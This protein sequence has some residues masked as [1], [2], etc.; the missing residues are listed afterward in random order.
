MTVENA[1][2]LLTLV[3]IKPLLI[4]MVIIAGLLLLHRRSAA[5]QH[6]WLSIGIFSLLLLPLLFRLLPEI[7]WQILPYTDGSSV[8]MNQVYGAVSWISQADR[9]W[10]IAAAYLFIAFWLLFYLLLGIVGLVIQT[11]QA[12]TC[13]DAELQSI[14]Q[15]LIVEMDISRTV[16]VV[17]SDAVLSPHMWGIF[18]PVIMLPRQAERWTGER[19]LSVL[20]HEL[21]H[22]ARYDWATSLAVKLCC[23]FFWFLPPVWWLAGRLFHYA[24]IACDDYI[25]CLQKDYQLR[26]KEAVYA[27]NLLA[28][29]QTAGKNTTPHADPALLMAGHSPIF[30]RIEAILD[31]DRQRDNAR[32]EAR[33]YWVLMVLLLLLPLASIQLIPIQQRLA[34]QVL[35]ITISDGDRIESNAAYKSTVPV[36]QFD[37]ETLSKLKQQLRGESSPVLPVEKMTIIA[38]RDN[39]NSAALRDAL[40]IDAYLAAP[41]PLVQV[42]GYMPLDIVIPEYPRHALQRGIEG[43]VVVSFSIAED[44][45]IFAAHIIRSHPRQVFDKS[46]LTALQHS[47]YKPQII[48]GLPVIIEGVTETFTFL[49]ES[50]SVADKRRR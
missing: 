26:N 17:T 49:I 14:L 13:E 19:K 20:L 25:Y 6:F 50:P 3:L 47:R 39:L 36:H 5:L 23:A 16:K 46:V 11:R 2:V 18:N 44:G 22:V 27:E 42:Q 9:F 8:I 48:D 33:H 38:S 41:T 35:H 37:A 32:P 24:E 1:L 15:E 40:P 43:E 12:T 29:A 4:S 10:Y 34:A 30:Y 28:M 31:R 21:G 45:S 7:E